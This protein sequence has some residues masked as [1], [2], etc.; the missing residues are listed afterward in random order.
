MYSIYHRQCL[1]LFV[2][3]F[4]SIWFFKSKDIFNFKKQTI[5]F[6]EP[7]LILHLNLY[8]AKCKKYFNFLKPKLFKYLLM[9]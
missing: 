2:L 7:K 4:K 8:L 3:F 6:I 9:A 1:K 5:Y